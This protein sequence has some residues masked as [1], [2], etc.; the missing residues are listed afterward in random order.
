MY[1]KILKII[2]ICSFL[3][4]FGANSGCIEDP[5]SASYRSDSLNLGKIDL[6]EIIKRANNAGYSAEHEVTYSGG[7]QPV[8]Y[9]E[10]LNEKIGNDYKITNVHYIYND[11]GLTLSLNEMP[12]RE[13]SATLTFL[14]S[15]DIPLNEE[16]P[17]DWIAEILIISFSMNR[18]NAGNYVALMKSQL[19]M[20][21]VQTDEPL[22]VWVENGNTEE[23][24]FGQARVWV[25]EEPDINSIYDY[26][27]D[28]STN[29]SVK[30]NHPGNCWEDFFNGEKKI[31]SIDYTLPLVT[32]TRK[33]GEH[34]CRL[35]MDNNGIIR[36]TVKLKEIETEIPEREYKAVLKEMFV[37]LGFSPEIVDNFVFSYDPYH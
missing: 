4:A 12:Q 34:T 30:F 2:I 13:N 22:M 20:E 9:I 28:E 25:T 31:G 29:S 24:K 11:I 26:L 27:D 5:N 21:T 8:S 23:G 3:L 7:L 19:Q 16:V 33:S 15:Y 6:D 17:D 18:Q 1:Q 10:G 32:V 37:D 35:Y 36:I 14:G